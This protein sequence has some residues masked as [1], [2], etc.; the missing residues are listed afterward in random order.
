MAIEINIYGTKES[1]VS[2]FL[3]FVVKS[4]K[5]NKCSI[6]VKNFIDGNIEN[7]GKQLFGKKVIFSA[8]VILIR[9]WK[10]KFWHV[11]CV[12]N[13]NNLTITRYFINKI[14]G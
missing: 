2:F 13:R 12:R 6:E 3:D 10:Q 14:F 9:L 4:K 11:I 8:R 1:A 5:T 7:A